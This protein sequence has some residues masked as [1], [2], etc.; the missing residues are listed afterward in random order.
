M[1]VGYKQTEVGVIP[2][3]WETS[4]VGYEFTIQLGKMLDSER[5]TG[6][7]K[8]Y[9]GNRAVQWDQID[10]SDLATVPM[11][12]GDLKKFRLKKGDILVCEGG[13][14]GRAAI[15]NSPLSECYYQKALHRLRPLKGFNSKLMVAILRRWADKGVLKNYVTQTSIAHLPRDKFLTIPIPV[16][17]REE[18]RAIAT[19][20][21]NVDALLE[22]LD[23]LIA[24]KRDIKQ[25][26]M[27]QLLT[28]QTRLPGFEEEWETVRAGDIG[29]FRGGSGFPTRFQGVSSGAYPFFKVSDMNNEGNSTFMESANHCIS[30]PVRK[31]IGAVVFPSGAIVFAKVG[32][33]VFLERKKILTKPSCIDNNMAGYIVNTE[34]V[35]VRFI[36]YA[37]LRKALGDLVSTTALPSLNGSALSAMEFHL[38]QLEEQIAIARALSDIDA[39]LQMQEQRRAKTAA[40][41]QAMMQELLTGR[42][43]L[44]TQGEE[45]AE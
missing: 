17:P 14:V 41:K 40:L 22:E 34:R 38:P 19:A 1:P 10:I 36:Y 32:A 24:K 8:P 9:L 7:R 33:A 28:G 16:P 30:E 35:D 25:A 29:R 2:E 3:D 45:G 5:N 37:L 20:L 42:T 15:W 23:R 27:Q 31:Q 11:S 39:E 44:T 12:Q 4:S 18:Q 43:R 6:V 13:E 26:I 21:S